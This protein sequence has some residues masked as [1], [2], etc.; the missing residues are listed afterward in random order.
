MKSIRKT[1]RN[2]G[3]GLATL[4]LLALGPLGLFPT[5]PVHASAFTV[6]TST[7]VPF[8]LVVFV[9]CALGGAGEFVELSGE[10]R[11]LFHVTLDNSGGCLTKFHDNPQGISGTGQ[12]SG[13]K[14][15]GTGVT[16]GTSNNCKVGS[17]TTSVNNF[18]IIGQGPGNNFL[19]HENLHF[20]V[21][22]NGSV[23]SFHDNFSV[24]CK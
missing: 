3:V 18:R 12:T 13:D 2:L 24:E 14:Y 16:Q 17:E 6:T 9:P 1:I 11:D 23:T 5:L 20:T 8:D 15:Q 21:N 10:V 4:G 7:S 19:L 22:A